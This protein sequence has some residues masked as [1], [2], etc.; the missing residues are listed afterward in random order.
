MPYDAPDSGLNRPTISFAELDASHGA[1]PW[2]APLVASPSV[3]I[4]LLCMTA[5]T[6]TVPHYHPRAVEAF[7]VIRGVVGLTIG[8]APELITEP[9]SV[10]L[11]PRGVVHGIRV[12][13]PDSALLMCTVAPNEDAP[14]EQVEIAR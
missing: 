5:G 9:G 6:Q 8:D 14:D 10:V 12:P 1:A 4:V 13:G 7:Q 2:R 11:A 3:R